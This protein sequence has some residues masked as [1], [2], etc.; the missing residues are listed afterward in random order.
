MKSARSHPV[1]YLCLRAR[2]ANVGGVALGSLV[3]RGKPGQ[4]GPRY[5]WSRRVE[6]KT[7]SVALSKEQFDW[8]QE[9]INN[10]REAWDLLSE[11]HQMTHEHLWKH[12]PSTSRRKRLTK[13]TMGLK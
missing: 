9:A 3:E 8:L 11:M 12:L 6:G 2:L 5:Q 4:G 7:V 10:Q 13:N 1:A